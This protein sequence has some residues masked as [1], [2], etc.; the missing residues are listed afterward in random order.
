M[1][2]FTC[3]QK[4]SYLAPDILDI[5]EGNQTSVDLQ[6]PLDAFCRSASTTTV[7]DLHHENDLFST[8]TKH[9]SSQDSLDKLHGH[10]NRKAFLF[11]RTHS[12][13]PELKFYRRKHF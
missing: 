1:P 7:A 2:F 13:S 9:S 3:F 6:L 5:I 12:P 8:L 4:Q 10:N 11:N